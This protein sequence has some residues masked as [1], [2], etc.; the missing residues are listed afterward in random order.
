MRW[1]RLTVILGLSNLVLLALA[2][3]RPLVADTAPP[4]LRGRA[5]ELVDERGRVRAEI[6]VL[7]ADPNVTMPDGSKGYPETVLLRLIDSEGG[8]NVK[9]ASTEDGAGLVLGGDSAYVQILSRAST[10]F[11]KIVSKDGGRTIDAKQMGSGGR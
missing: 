3:V 7:P 9:L 11:I 2:V 10:P 8:P 1:Q 6:K 5:L 4:V